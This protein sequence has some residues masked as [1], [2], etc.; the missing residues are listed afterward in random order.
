MIKVPNKKSLES[1]QK[2]K[3]LEL[4][5]DFK[6]EKAQKFTT[7]VLTLV[8]L[9]FFGIF[10]INPT[11]TTIAKLRKELADN[12][13]IDQQLQKKINDLYIL[14]Q[15]YASLQNDLPVIYSA[16]PKKP[17]VPL[18]VAQ[19]QAVAKNSNVS[20][21]GIQVSQIELTKQDPT[22][23]DYSSYAF[24]FST[25]GTFEDLSKFISSLGSMQRI[26]SIDN[27]SI[28]KDSEGSNLTLNV[29]GM[30][31]FKN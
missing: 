9:S 30:S 13:L 22:E 16:I 10:A 28:G 12:K 21:T 4:L 18:L 27:V 26:I 20:I 5:P 25:Q 23:K 3:Y 2:N 1:F 29:K 31:I 14:Q 15:K 11:I 24:S 6:E 17:E 8:A 7:L 19:I